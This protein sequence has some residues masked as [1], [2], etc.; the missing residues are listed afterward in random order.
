MNMNYIKFHSSKVQN[1]INAPK[2]MHHVQQN[3][4]VTTAI[5]MWWA[6]LK[7]ILVDKKW[8]QDILKILGLD[9]GPLNH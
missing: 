3:S 1:T 8:S 9:V 4:I 5:I 2:H 7:E 6:F